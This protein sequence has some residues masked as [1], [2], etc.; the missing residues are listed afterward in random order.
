MRLPDQPCPILGGHWTS[1][2][3]RGDDTNPANRPVI[4]TARMLTREESLS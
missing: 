3:V 4:T 2:R 1:R